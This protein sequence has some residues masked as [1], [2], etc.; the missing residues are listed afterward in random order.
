MKK[1]IAYVISL[2]LVLSIG[3][4]VGAIASNGTKT[5]TL[6]YRDIKITLDGKE[7]I[8]KDVDGNYVEPFII[9]GT[10]YLPVRGISNALGLNVDWDG[11]SG[12]V[13]LTTPTNIPSGA[14]LFEK[15]DVKITYLGLVASDSYLGGY[16]V[17]LQIEN[18]SSKDYIVQIRDLS[19]N[20]FM[21]DSVFSCEVAAGKKANDEIRIYKSA[22]DKNNIT[23]IENLEFYFAVLDSDTFLE[24]FKS[25]IISISK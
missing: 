12:T 8:P 24:S 10:T 17:K 21:T 9:D 7:L 20:G 11:V 15:N 14:V 2:V 18:N 25:N 3:F 16:D 5:A 19:V 22:L 13:I 1:K 6:F 4:S 23:N